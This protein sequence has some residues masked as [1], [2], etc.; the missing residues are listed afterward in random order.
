MTASVVLIGTGG[1]GR[2]WWPSL[3]AAEYRVVAVVEPDIDERRAAAARSAS[4]TT[5]FSTS[6]GTGR[7]S[8]RTSSS[9]E[10]F[11]AHPGNAAAARAAGA[12]LL[13]AKP[14]APTVAEA[15]EMVLRGHEAGTEL[16]VAQQMRYF[17]CF[18]ALRQ[19]LSDGRVEGGVGRP[20][21]ARIRMALDGRGWVP[22]MA[23][24]LAMDHPLLMEAGIHHFDLMRYVFATE[25]TDVSAVSWN[26]PWSPF[27][28]DASV[29]AVLHAE[30]G[31]V[32]TYDATFA[33][34]PGSEAVRFDSGW[35]VVCT[36]G[37]L[38]VVDGGLYRDGELIGGAAAAQPVSLEDL[39]RELLA[40]W[41]R[42]RADGTEC[43]I[44][45]R[46][47]L[48][49]LEMVAAAIDSCAGKE[50]R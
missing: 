33:P 11:P 4:P 36:G 29:C 16:A 46:A 38:T 48:A 45:G 14:I 5:A 25:F 20:V 39:N 50:A 42:A 47:N 40:D 41:R 8:V 23:W 1:F 17:P 27:S 10:P 30:S 31:P 21:A 15:R 44:S 2:T 43:G 9:L 28:G 7:A 19:A 26:P 13:V 18:R 24:R 6:A 12:D 32:V 3:E 49:G 22:G 37:T 35:E 34:P